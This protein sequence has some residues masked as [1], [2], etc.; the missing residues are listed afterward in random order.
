MRFTTCLIDSETERHI[1]YKKK[2]AE[3]GG[4]CR[5]QERDRAGG[6]EARITAKHNK[7]NERDDKCSIMALHV[8][9]AATLFSLPGHHYRHP[10]RSSRL[11]TAIATTQP[12]PFH[13]Q[14]IYTEIFHT[15]YI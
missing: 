13:H 7:K 5:E 15:I 11:S 6:S 8:Y 1:E 9:N 14:P 2:V 10:I 12:L 3:L 4:A